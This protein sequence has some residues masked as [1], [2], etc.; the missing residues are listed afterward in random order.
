MQLGRVECALAGLV[1]YRFTRLRIER[2]DDIVP[3][4]A[5]NEN[6]T[7]WTGGADTQVRCAT[8]ELVLIRH[9]HKQN[10]LTHDLAGKVMQQL[11]TG[12]TSGV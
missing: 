2:G 9:A 11:Q 6:A 12:L 10:L 7:H 5:A 4:F 1:D 3:R 8:L